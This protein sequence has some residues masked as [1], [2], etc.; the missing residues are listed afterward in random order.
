MNNKELERQLNI[1]LNI[2]NDNLPVSAEK[3]NQIIGLSLIYKNDIDISEIR[4]LK[5]LKALELFNFNL[6]TEIIDAI[7]KLSKLSS[8]VLYNCESSSIIKL[9]QLDNIVLDGCKNLDISKV[10]FPDKCTIIHSGI[11]DAS[12]FIHAKRLK[13]LRIYNSS[14]INS[15]YLEYIPNLESLNIDG[16]TVDDESIVTRLKSKKV[17]VSNMPDYKPV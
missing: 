17:I 11:V 1:E 6:T 5:N 7:K 15:S 3:Y 13:D 10:Y 14:I 16:T 9:N 2:F 12:Y 4:Y 8:L